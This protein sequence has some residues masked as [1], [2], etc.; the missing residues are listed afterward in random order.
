MLRSI[1]NGLTIPPY[2]KIKNTSRIY[3][4][5]EGPGRMEMV[6]EM[7]VEQRLPSPQM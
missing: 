2:D 1:T 3:G 4:Y 6:M 7:A 5:R